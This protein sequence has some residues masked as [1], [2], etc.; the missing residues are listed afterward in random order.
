MLCIVNKVIPAKAGAF[1]YPGALLPG[2]I[3]QLRSFALDAL[4]KKRPDAQPVTEE[5]ARSFLVDVSMAAM[6]DFEALGK[7]RDVRVTA[8]D[9]NGGALVDGDRVVHL[10]VFR[11]E[12]DSDGQKKTSTR[13]IRG[14][15]RG[16]RG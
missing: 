14:S 15:M 16:R 2:V 11:T 6:E 7:G 13:L 3:E 10:C 12:D 8:K 1:R 4:E 9:I 5:G